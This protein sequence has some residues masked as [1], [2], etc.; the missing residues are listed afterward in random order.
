MP[1]GTTDPDG[2]FVLGSDK[3]I[4]IVYSIGDGP[5]RTFTYGPNFTL[6]YIPKPNTLHTAHFNFVGDEFVVMFQ[7]D[8]NNWQNGS[9]NNVTIN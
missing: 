4:K 8:E 1:D 2:K 9:D 6:N 7:A 3:E 5:E